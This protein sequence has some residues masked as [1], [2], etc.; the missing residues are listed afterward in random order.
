MRSTLSFNIYFKR[1]NNNKTIYLAL[2]FFSI[3]FVA[4]DSLFRE[5]F[6]FTNESKPAFSHGPKGKERV[7]TGM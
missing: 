2:E 6:I 5:Q 7:I 3:I 4:P 1:V